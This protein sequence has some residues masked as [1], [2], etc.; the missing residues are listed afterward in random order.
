MNPRDKK[1]KT[2]FLKIYEIQ[3]Y[4]NNQVFD[5]GLGFPSGIPGQD[6]IYAK[7]QIIKIN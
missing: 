1:L 7:I 4:T 3:Y 2:N 6:E 5:N